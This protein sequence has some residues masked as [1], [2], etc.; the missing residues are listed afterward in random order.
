MSAIIFEKKSII[1]VIRPRYYNE[2]LDAC[3]KGIDEYCQIYGYR[4][5]T[6]TVNDTTEQTFR[7]HQIFDRYQSIGLDCRSV[8]G[9]EY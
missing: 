7:S 3:Q 4:T 1:G 5:V 2:F 6:C 9:H 8:N